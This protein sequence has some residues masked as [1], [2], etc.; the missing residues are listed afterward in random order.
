MEFNNR[1][2][3]GAVE[4]QNATQSAKLF[5]GQI[6]KDMNEEVLSTYFEEFGSIK[7]LSIIRDTTSGYSRG[8]AFVTYFDNESAEK[9][10]ENLHDKVKLPNAVNFLQVRFAET[11]VEKENKL[12][13]G[14]LPKTFSE[15][16]LHQLF[17]PFGE[18]K[19][20]HIIRGPEGSP[21]G[22]AFVKFVERDGAINAI[23]QLNETIPAGATRPLVVKFAE[24][25]RGGGRDHGNFNNQNFMKNEHWFGNQ[26]NAQLG[27][28]FMVDPNSQ[29][30]AA[31]NMFTYSM[32]NPAVSGM[33]PGMMSFQMRP[34]VGGNPGFSMGEPPRQ[35]AAMTPLGYGAMPFN[36]AQAS[37]SK[38]YRDMNDPANRGFQGG[39]EQSHHHHQR[40]PEGPV[41]AN[42]F[43]YHL[44]RDLTDADLATLFA[45]F[46]NVISAKVFVDKKT[47]DSKGFGFVSYDSFESANSAIE[48]M[49]GFQIGSKRLKVQHKRVLGP[50]AAPGMMKEHD[51]QFPRNMMMHN[52]ANVPLN[53]MMNKIGGPELGPGGLP[54]AAYGANTRFEY[55]GAAVNMPPPQFVVPP[56]IAGNR[57]HPPGSYQP[58]NLE[59]DSFNLQEYMPSNNIKHL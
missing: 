27:G 6:P 20:V 13:V 46:G 3:L 44:P 25:K 37:M 8:C 28:Q 22:C 33:A 40:P 56:T 10:V 35:V 12:F 31:R 57:T 55:P 50:G 18:L 48:S 11:Q 42:L 29:N 32:P 1:L 39:Q 5:V 38:P 26:Q 52:L 23:N 17:L 59:M 7:E 49:N 2:E 51:N 41:G 16:D 47:S 34:P 54:Q 43:I 24:S 4:E 19:E 14:M 45:P 9:A 30:P 21:K 15:H 36:P 58:H 53:P